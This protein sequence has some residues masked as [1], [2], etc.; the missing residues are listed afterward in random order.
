MSTRR[1]VG[2]GTGATGAAL[3]GLARACHPEPTVA[4]TAVASALAAS[5]GRPWPGV[6]AV[7]GAVLCGQLSVGWSNDYLDRE[8]DRAAR[9][10]DKPLAAAQVPAGI[11]GAAALVALLA[12]V[13]LSLL[14]G[15]VAGAV[16]LA[17]V[18]CAWSYNLGVKATAFSILPYTAAFGLL[19]AYVV[20]G[21]PGHPAYAAAKG[22]LAALTRQ[23][24]VE[25]G[26]ELRVNCVLP[27][28]VRTAAWDRVSDDDRRRSAAA[29]VARRLG[30]PGEVA[31][32]IAFLA[33]PDASFIT[34]AG[35]VVDGGWSIARDSA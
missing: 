4:V 3:G 17:A 12:C 1:P 33:S 19:P 21:L 20:M 29:T 16:H 9:R 13:P 23:L 11:V 30:R 6:L 8:R 25:Y 10:V 14:S 26:P 18:A 32:A 5:T 31:A 2:A 7:L 24:A 22:G 15:L 28:P 27:G 34:G 35:L